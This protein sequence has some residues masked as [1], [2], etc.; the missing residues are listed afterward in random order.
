MC[1]SWTHQTGEAPL[2]S[3][4]GG[5]ITTYRSLPKRRSAQ[6]AAH[7]PTRTGLAAGWTGT[8]PLPGGEF[9]IDECRRSLRSN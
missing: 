1:W 6:I 9:D 2:L 5:K 3:I 8:A 7:L 4:I